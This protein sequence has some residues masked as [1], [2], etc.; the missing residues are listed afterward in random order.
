VGSFLSSI[1]LSINAALPKLPTCYT[2]NSF[3][4][5]RAYNILFAA[6]LLHLSTF[7]VLAFPALLSNKSLCYLALATFA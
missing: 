2:L 7:S 6:A 1:P 3:L 5:P 4:P